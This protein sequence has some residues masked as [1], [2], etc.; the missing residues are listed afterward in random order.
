[1]ITYAIIPARSGSKRFKNK[2]VSKFINIPLFLH[3]IN[4]AKKLKFVDKIIFTSDSK[5][6]LNLAKT[7]IKLIKHLRPKSSSRNNSMEEH[8]L[9]DLIKFFE[10]KNIKKPDCILWLRPT[11]P[12]R[13]IKTFMKAYNLFKKNKNLTV[14]VVHKVDSRIFKVKKNFLI[15]INN[16]MKDRSMIKSQ[17]TQ[18]FYSIFSGELFKFSNKI[19]KNFLGKKKMFVEASKYTNFDIDNKS[20]LNI[21]QNLV[22]FNYKVYKNYLHIK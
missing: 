19:N 6:Y 10:K 22:K 12:L 11:H 17:D 18:P 21:L 9:V 14:M 3:S 20:D 7:N 4:F 15:P 2:N 5:K 16:K 13:D 8:I 1:M